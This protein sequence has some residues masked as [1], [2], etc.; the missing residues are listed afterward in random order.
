MNF[1][2]VE[3][4]NELSVIA[5]RESSIRVLNPDQKGSLEWHEWLQ[6]QN[7]IEDL[8]MLASRFHHQIE[9]LIFRFFEACEEIDNNFRYGFTSKV[10]LS[11]NCYSSLRKFF[12]LVFISKEYA[13]DKIY[14]YTSDETLKHFVFSIS[15][16]RIPCFRRSLLPVFKRSAR[17]ALR[18]LLS[19]KGAPSDIVCFSLS[20]NA[21]GDT[22]DSYFSDFFAE[23]K[24]SVKRVYLSSG[25]RINLPST[26]T[27]TPLEAYASFFDVIHCAFISI[28]DQKYNDVLIF[29]NMDLTFIFNTLKHAEHST[30]S[31]FTSLLIERIGERV[32]GKEIPRTLI[33]PYEN[34][35]WEKRLIKAARGKG[36]KRIIGYQ[37]SSITPRHLSF[38][39]AAKESYNSFLPDKIITAGTVTSN[40]LKNNASALSQLVVSGASLR[41]V[42]KNIDSSDNQRVLVP[43]S[44]SRAEALSLLNIVWSA[45]ETSSKQFVIRTHPTIPIDDLFNQFDWPDRVLLSDGMSLEEDLERTSIVAYT[46]STVALDGMLFCKP[47]IFI[48]IGD[49]PSGDPLL[50][51]DSLRATVRSGVALAKEVDRIFEMSK[52]ESDVEAKRLKEYAENYLVSVSGFG[53]DALA[54]LFEVCVND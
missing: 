33:F 3:D 44:S 31:Y 9:G 24:Y 8:S 28:S 18:S 16:V 10:L 41:R 12:E 22:N 36:V 21:R 26:E 29:E 27:S 43:I 37:H 13:D 38:K 17:S 52:S 6:E 47:V 5:N 39:M 2:F 54:D 45:L 4:L 48:D 14:V 11:I 46:S 19:I 25:N 40:W 30:G 49:I 34:R 32:V 51:N 42:E 53:G 50:E 35:S 1:C 15:E 7:N 23:N 20:H